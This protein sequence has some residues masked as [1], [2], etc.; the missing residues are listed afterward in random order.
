VVGL[1]LSGKR[2]VLPFAAQLKPAEP[3]AACCASGSNRSPGVWPKCVASA[4]AGSSIRRRAEIQVVL[5]RR[6]TPMR[7]KLNAVQRGHSSAVYPADQLFLPLWIRT[8]RRM[9]WMII[10][11]AILADLRG[12][13]RHLPH[14]IGRSLQ[15]HTGRSSQADSLPGISLTAEPR[16]VPSHIR[17]VSRCSPKLM[18][19]KLPSLRFTT[20][21][22][23]LEKRRAARSAY[24]SGVRWRVWRCLR[25]KGGA[26]AGAAERW[27]ERLAGL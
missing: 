15:S 20:R 3:I 9:S 26:G 22:D 10:G 13:I 12:F 17:Q 5:L 19:L 1:T 7:A 6:S 11:R 4:E 8:L 24:E 23:L 25:S 21:C 16:T 14:K 2:A 27:P 18:R